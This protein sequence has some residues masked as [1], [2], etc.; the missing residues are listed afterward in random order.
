MA[1]LSPELRALLAPTGKLRVGIND[2]N[3]L[4]VTKSLEA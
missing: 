2:G 1:L 4:L 3:A